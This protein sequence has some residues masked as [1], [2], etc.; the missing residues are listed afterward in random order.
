M[1]LCVQSLSLAHMSGVLED[2]KWLCF[3]ALYFSVL[4]EYLLLKPRMSGSKCKKSSEVADLAEEPKRFI[5][6]EMARGF[7]L[8]EEALLDLRHKT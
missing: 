2:F 8:F 5:T 3:C 6:Q 7:S 4:A 1:R